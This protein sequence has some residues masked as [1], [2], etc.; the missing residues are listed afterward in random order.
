MTPNSTV[1]VPLIVNCAQL[2]AASVTISAG[3]PL[4]STSACPTQHRGVGRHNIAHLHN[5]PEQGDCRSWP[6]SPSSRVKGTGAPKTRGSPEPRRYSRANTLPSTTGEPLVVTVLVTSKPPNSS[7]ALF[8]GRR[9]SLLAGEHQRVPS[10][11]GVE[12]T[13]SPS[14]RLRR[15]G[16]PAR[17][18]CAPHRR[19]PDD[20]RL[21]QRRYLTD[22]DRRAVR[23]GLHR[24]HGTAGHDRSEVRRRGSHRLCTG[25]RTSD[26]GAARP[27]HAAS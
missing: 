1:S 12:G 24:V 3:S 7:T 27:P 11:G 22:E 2:P 20:V 19:I 6:L 26:W 5:S 25:T 23:D 16:G 8:V 13:A 10:R 4:I 15:D 14:R 21:V 17:G 18:R 9:Q